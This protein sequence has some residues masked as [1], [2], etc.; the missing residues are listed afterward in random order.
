MQN[1]E[2]NNSEIGL[3]TDAD[4]DAING[5][6]CVGDFFR[7]IG[8]AIEGAAGFVGGLIW[9]GLHGQPG[10]WRGPFGPHPL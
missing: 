1:M 8:G 7:A 9:N 4:L 3:L 2:Q 6:N 5:G 10:P